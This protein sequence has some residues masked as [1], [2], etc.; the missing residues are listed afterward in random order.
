V[1]VGRK[2]FF[3]TQELKVLGEVIEDDLEATE[4]LQAHLEKDGGSCLRG[5]VDEL[6]QSTGMVDAIV[7]EEVLRRVKIKLDGGE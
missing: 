3:D 4:S 2:V 1:T 6:G 5:E 7:R